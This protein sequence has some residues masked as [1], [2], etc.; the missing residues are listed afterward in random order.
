MCTKLEPDSSKIHETLEINFLRKFSP[1][2]LYS[3]P[4]TFL[5]NAFTVLIISI[6]SEI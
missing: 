6:D 5:K 4:F 3:F 1:R 2:A